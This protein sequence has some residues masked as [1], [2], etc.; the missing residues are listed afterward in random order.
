[1]AENGRSP[2]EAK[3][4]KEP[5]K[6][7]CPGMVYSERGEAAKVAYIGKVAHYAIPDRGFWRHV[8]AYEVDR[9]V[10]AELKERI[11]SVQN[12]LMP[13][14]LQML[15]KEDLFTK[16]AVT[17]SI[18]HL[19]EGMHSS[20]SEEWVP[21]LQMLGFRIVVNVHG[22]VVEIV[23]PQPSGEGDWE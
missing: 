4:G 5:R 16:A 14:V 21:F 2:K 11:S 1:M 8:A 15:G 23:Y 7:L 3:M 20:D 17:A 18:R 10:I 19:E 9:V 6:A 22:D 12:E 13:A